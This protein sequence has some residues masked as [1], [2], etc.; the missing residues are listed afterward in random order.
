M[1]LRRRFVILGLLAI[2]AVGAAVATIAQLFT[3]TDNAR[4]QAG[5]DTADAMVSAL[6]RAEV[7]S[8]A[9]E[10]EDDASLRSVAAGVVA[11]QIDAHAG[12]CMGAAVVIAVA[13]PGPRRELRH[14]ELPP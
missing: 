14:A 5:R 8:D 9:R 1:S 13:S 6:E 12:F 11:A 7:S 3:R 4:E 10:H 2:L